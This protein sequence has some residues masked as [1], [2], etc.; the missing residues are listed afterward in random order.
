MLGCAGDP[1]VGKKEDYLGGAGL[2][3]FCV[4]SD[5]AESKLNMGTRT[6]LL[7]SQKADGDFAKHA[8]LV[9]TFQSAMLALN[10][11]L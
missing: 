9:W 5:D 6:S 1:W 4:G 3:G 11:L 7:P 8:S 2:I 10:Q